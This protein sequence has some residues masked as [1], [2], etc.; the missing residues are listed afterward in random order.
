MLVLANADGFWV[1][2]YKLSQW[3][4]HT[5]GNRYG[6]AQGRIKVWK[7][8]SGKRGGRVHTG[9]GFADNIPATVV[10][11]FQKRRYQAFTFAR[12]GAV[13]DGNQG[14]VVGV[15]QAL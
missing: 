15:N 8:F 7:F 3:V 2:L 1:N 11:P 14:H 4:L 12:G 10:T 5:A 6:A 9:A 13:S